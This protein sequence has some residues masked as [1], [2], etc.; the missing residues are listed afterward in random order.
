MWIIAALVNGM[1][2]QVMPI[3]AQANIVLVIIV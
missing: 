1:I 2:V 3:A